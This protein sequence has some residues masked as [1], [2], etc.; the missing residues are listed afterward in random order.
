MRTFWNTKN[1]IEAISAWQ[2]SC[3]VQVTCPVEDDI[4]FLVNELHMP[5]YFITDVS[6]ADERARYDYDDGWLMIILRIPHLK[7]IS[8]RTPYTTIPLGVVIKK[9]VIVTS[10]TGVIEEGKMSSPSPESASFVTE[11]MGSKK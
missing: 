7:T 2:Q 8:S 9:D 11:A 10:Y 1:G 4:N 3:W 6:D 5:D